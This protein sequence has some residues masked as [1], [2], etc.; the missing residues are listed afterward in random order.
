M[1]SISRRRLQGSTSAEAGAVALFP[2]SATPQTAIQAAIT[3]VPPT[4]STIA[5]RDRRKQ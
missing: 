5:D 4:T 2:S 1:T 3:D